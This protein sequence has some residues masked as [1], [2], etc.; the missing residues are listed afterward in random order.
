MSAKGTTLAVA[1]VFATAIATA[2]AT[3]AAIYHYGTPGSDQNETQAAAVSEDQDIGPQIRDYLLENPEI[4]LD[5]QAALREK[6]VAE[7]QKAAAEVLAQNQEKLYQPDYD[8]ELGNPDGAITV[9]EFFDYNCGYCR[10]ALAD[11]DELIATNDDVRFILKE[12]PVLGPE[13]EAVQRVSYAFMRIAP[14]KYEDFHRALMQSGGRAT[15]DTALA[16]ADSLGFDAE[17]MQQ[18]MVDYPGDEALQEHFALASS[19]G[20]NGTPAYIVGDALISGAVGADTLQDR[21]DNVRECGSATC[22]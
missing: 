19:I 4:L 20:V 3:T 15:E 9:V 14:E 2:A 13:S 22:S 7:Q 6:Q 17:T 18:A 11:M 10:R 21:I 1:A 8:F 12:I 5:V 16:V